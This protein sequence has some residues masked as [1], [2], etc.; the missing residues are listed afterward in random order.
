MID[1]PALAAR[2]TEKGLIDKTFYD[3]N[4]DEVMAMCDAVL[5]AHNPEHEVVPYI[6]YDLHEPVLV[7]PRNS[8]KRFMRVHLTG[9]DARDALR[10]TLELLGADYEMM[11]RYLGDSWNDEP[12]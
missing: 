12:Q 5:A 11:R 1:L 8:S 4:H 7:V 2:L 9:K 10:E 3:M 6:K